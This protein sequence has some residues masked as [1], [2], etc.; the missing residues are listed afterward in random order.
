MKIPNAFLH[1]KYKVHWDVKSDRNKTDKL[2][3]TGRWPPTDVQALLPGICKYVSLHSKMGFAD[4][5][6]VMGIHYQGKPN[7]THEPLEAMNC[8][9]CHIP[10]CI[11][12]ISTLNIY[13]LYS[14]CGGGM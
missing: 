12:Y 8:I 3:V 10:V 11:F 1:Q 4:V 2:H 7:L 6:K 14:W 5:V 9:F 13:F